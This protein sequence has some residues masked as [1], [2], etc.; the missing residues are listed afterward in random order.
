MDPSTSKATHEVSTISFEVMPPRRPDK[1]DDFWTMIDTLLTAQPDFISVTYGAGGKNRFTARDV[2]TRISRDTPISPIAHLTCIGP[3]VRT[4]E[5]TIE[6]YLAADVR[7]FLA[8][9]GDPPAD[10]PDWRPPLGGVSSATE[11]VALIRSVETRRCARHRSAA[12]RAAVRP[13]TIAVAAFPSGNPAAGTTPEQEVERLLLK[14]AAGANFA[15]TQLFWDSETYISFVDKA[16]RAGVN[17]PILAGILVPTNARRLTRTCE[18]TGIQPPA[19]LLRGLELAD[20]DRAAT[21]FAVAELEKVARDV[22][23]S[24]APGIHLY[25]YNQPEASIDLLGRVGIL[26]YTR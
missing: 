2:V 5:A 6:D 25:T 24:G 8:I 9:R 22:L 26:E 13:L 17:I 14:Q 10:E 16:R 1:V 12:L 18:L 21:E 20:D 15:I 7:S 3:S 11:L 23:D 19:S 4:V